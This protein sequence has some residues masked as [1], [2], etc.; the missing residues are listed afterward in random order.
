MTDGVRFAKWGLGLFLFEVFLTFGIVA[1]YCVGARW[2]TGELF[3]QNITLWL[4]CPWTFSV[5][6]N[7]W[8]L[9]QALFIAVYFAG[10]LL[11]FGAVWR[12]L[13]ADPARPV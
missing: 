7:A 11:M 9:G 12:V 13:D 6:K 10:A 4:A 5:G 8:L 1:Q 2:P 3:M